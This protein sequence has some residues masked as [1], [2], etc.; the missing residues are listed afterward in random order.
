MLGYLY[1]CCVRWT[2]NKILFEKYSYINADLLC[3]TSY[4]NR[5]QHSHHKYNPINPNTPQH[6]IIT[7]SF[8]DSVCKCEPTTWGVQ[9]SVLPPISLTLSVPGAAH[10]ITWGATTQSSGCRGLLELAMVRVNMGSTWPS[11][12]QRT[13]CPMEHLLDKWMWWQKTNAYPHPS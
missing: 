6:F 4:H 8:C 1:I 9:L 12:H 10:C 3:Y 11:S 5:H 7:G 13:S 2:C